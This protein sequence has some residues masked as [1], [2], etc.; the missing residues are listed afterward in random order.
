M[1]PTETRPKEAFTKRVQCFNQ[2][3]TIVAIC[4][5][6]LMSDSQD[7][8]LQMIGNDTPPYLIE[9]ICDKI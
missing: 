1:D 4:I 2:I 7:N 5:A 6:K 9:E 3:Q 8:V